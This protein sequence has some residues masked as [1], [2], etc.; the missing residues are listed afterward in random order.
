MLY[1]DPI[2][3]QG[4]PAAAHEYD[5]YAGQITS[6]LRRGCSERELADRLGQMRV[7]S[8]GLS[9]NKKADRLAAK[10]IHAWHQTAERSES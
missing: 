8:M 5:S 3:V 4:E 9:K 1:W 7:E 10:K 2:G 6:M